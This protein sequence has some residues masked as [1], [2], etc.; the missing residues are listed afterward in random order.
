M[1]AISIKSRVLRHL[2]STIILGLPILLPIMIL[3]SVLAWAVSKVDNLI[4]PL[5]QYA[6]FVPDIV[7][8][9]PGLGVILTLILSY[10]VGLVSFRKPGKLMVRLLRRIHGYEEVKKLI[11]M[12]LG[13]DKSSDQA[14]RIVLVEY[15]S[16]GISA[17]G[18]FMSESIIDGK[19]HIL[20]FIA[21]PPLPNNGAL[22]F[23]PRDKVRYAVILGVESNEQ[24]Y[25]S[26]AEYMK[27]IISAGTVAPPNI[28]TAP[29]E[30]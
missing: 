2:R 17:L 5:L 18:L 23:I 14:N 13:L 9:I 25:M 29:L 21:T 30:E 11:S 27:Y 4:R 12:L 28:K 15:P 10:I 16:S 19:P 24:G 26:R 8:V 3:V 1:K 22:A 6:P 7:L 20:V